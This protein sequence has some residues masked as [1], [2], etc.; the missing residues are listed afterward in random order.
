MAN[1]A[2][3]EE[4]H[5]AAVQAALNR[6]AREAQ[7]KQDTA[8]ELLTQKL[9]QL[10]IAGNNVVEAAA[11]IQT[12][13][14]TMRDQVHQE[15]ERLRQV[16]ADVQR[17]SQHAQGALEQI[18]SIM[19]DE[20]CL[21]QRMNQTLQLCQESSNRA[22]HAE[23][24]A[25]ADANIAV[26]A[27][28]RLETLRM[29]TQSLLQGL[30]QAALAGAQTPGDNNANPSISE[31][32]LRALEATVRTM[33]DAPLP[34]PTLSGLDAHGMGDCLRRCEQLEKQML[35]CT[36]F[37][38]RYRTMEREIQELKRRPTNATPQAD[39][40]ASNLNMMERL[41]SAP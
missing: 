20:Q 11:E 9:Q 38:R 17:N 41:A 37:E 25:T 16:S 12:Q 27:I 39:P 33:Q 15:G 28:A 2:K 10:K 32:R 1:S 18:Q 7:Q 29:E 19:R 26:N 3:R 24:N 4:E 40:A 35:E 31:V 8:D 22:A 14:Q 5:Q 30:Q 23:Q 21:Q 13:T 6:V 36:A 34:Q